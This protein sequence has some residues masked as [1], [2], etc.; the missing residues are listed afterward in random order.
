MVSARPF[1]VLFL[2][3]LLSAR[4]S[5]PNLSIQTSSGTIHG[6]INETVP[7]VRQWLGIPFAQAPVGDLRWLAPLPLPS[8][9][10]SQE[11]NAASWAPNC[12]QYE[13][14]VPSVYNQLVREFFI[15]GGDS[16]DCLSLSIWAPYNTSH[17][18]LPV[19]VF[20]YGGGLTTGGSTVPYQNPSKW[21]ARTQ[22]HIVVSIQY[23]LNIFGFP[24]YPS[25]PDQNLGFLDQR[26]GLEW[27]QA[28]I[29]NFGGNPDQMVLWG[30]S[31]GAQSTDV[32]DF[33]WYNESIVQGYISDSGAALAMPATT[34]LNGSSFEAVAAF[35]GCTGDS[36][37]LLE[38]FRDAPW[39]DI[40]AYLQVY[41]DTKRSP[42]LS[43][44]AYPD[45]IRYFA[46]FTERLEQGLV[47]G[48]PHIFG[49][50]ERDTASTGGAV[51]PTSDPATTPATNPLG[52]LSDA[53]NGVYFLCGGAT[54][55]SIR[56]TLNLTTYR[57]QYNGNFT[58]ISPYG[59]L[60]AYHSSELPMIFGTYDDFRG[61]G[62]ELEMETSLMMQDLW[63]AFAED[64]ESGPERLGW[65]KHVSGKNAMFGGST[66]YGLG[67]D[68]AFKT[69][70][71]GIIEGICFES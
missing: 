7:T 16:E 19:V 60:G 28:N 26:L 64:P 9:A 35:F 63:L 29:G 23:R 22:S 34:V 46:N 15:W 67:S 70:D 2:C 20:L 56:D 6:V 66:P 59:W 14:T 32:Q 52:N 48:K 1:A 45:N 55:A 33:G 25:L 39:Q 71:S 24:N 69:V 51:W 12:P 40:E 57:F 49:N 18:P 30:Q 17:E 68:T 62:S 54:E 5:S 65:P 21:V 41:V 8:N 50:C 31:A 3:N 42:A 36:D 13:S 47:S 38:C 58:N 4:A 61:V 11:V 10:S 27:L 44:A 53:G 37:T 43:F